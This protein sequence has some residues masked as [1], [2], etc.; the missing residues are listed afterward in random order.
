MRLPQA[1]LET[2]SRRVLLTLAATLPVPLL[3][4]PGLAAERTTA[5]TVGIENK[6]TLSGAIGI[7]WGGRE[8]CDPT[9][10]TC[11]AGGVE[12]SAAD[13]REVPQPRAAVTERFVMDVLISGQTVGRL[14]LGV[15]RDA[16]PDSCD[17]FSQLARGTLRSEPD[18]VPAT[19]ERS[20]AF[21]V[22]KGREVVLGALKAP[23]GQLKLIAGKTK[24]QRFS[25]V[26]PRNKDTNAL[27]HDAAGLLSMRRG[28]G[29][30]AFVL[31]PEAN[32]ALDKEWIV[33]GQILDAEGMQILAR[34]NS[35]PTNNYDQSPLASVKLER[36]VPL[37]SGSATA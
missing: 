14:T 20:T 35:L 34:L 30:F 2:A 12:G 11:Q 23:S 31:T 3:P 33:I 19:L 7:I 27:S 32:A 9:D 8:R 26:P 24:P 22:L 5:Q 16:A 1:P 10:P 25:V 37:P 18:D 13:A 36:I 17:T 29:S 28:G 15:Y 21:R 6:E 4:L